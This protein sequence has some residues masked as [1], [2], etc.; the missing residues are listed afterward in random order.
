MGVRTCAHTHIYKL[1]IKMIEH[2]VF[3]A[4]KS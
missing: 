4:N 1:T 3:C 2:S